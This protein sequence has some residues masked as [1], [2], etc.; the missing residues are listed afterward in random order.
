MPIDFH[1]QTVDPAIHSLQDLNPINQSSLTQVRK[2]SPKSDHAD[3]DI[4]RVE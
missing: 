1:W 4:Q 2:K 3:D